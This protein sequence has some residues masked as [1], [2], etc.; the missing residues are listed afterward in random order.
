MM[1]ALNNVHIFL[2]P[3]FGKKIEAINAI[4]TKFPDAE[5]S[6]FYAGE[7]NISSITEALLNISLFADRKIITIKNA[8]QIKKKEDI[9]LLVSC[10][11]NMEKTT[12]LILLSEEFKLNAALE[13]AC[14]SANR[15]IFYEMFESEK[16]EWVRQFFLNEGY[17]IDKDCITAILELVENNTDALRRECSRL[18]AFLPKDKPEDQVINKDVIEQLL[19][20][21]R[22]ESAFTLFSRITQGDL[23]RALESMSVMLA[24]K[25]SASGILAGLTWCFRKLNDYLSLLEAGNENNNFELKKIGLSSP[26][27]RDDYSIAARRYNTESV[28]TCLNLT[29]EYEVLL[30]SPVS[31]M[32]NILMDRYILS[33][34]KTANK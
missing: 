26:K 22:E 12:C 18:I 11:K 27:A 25:E 23:S 31:I 7:T 9:E 6:V 21:N 1:A 34:I 32:E 14:K 29:A 8:C 24:S 3:E 5:E 30:R 28:E 10:L 17:K 33:I 4:K 19:S 13:E 20:H 16:N 2:G 15:R